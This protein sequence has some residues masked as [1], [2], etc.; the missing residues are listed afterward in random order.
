MSGRKRVSVLFA[1]VDRTICQEKFLVICQEAEAFLSR[2]LK[3]NFG[4][5]G[6]LPWHT[7]SW[8][9]QKLPYPLSPLAT[10]PTLW[11]GKGKK[12]GGP[13]LPCLGHGLEEGK[14]R[15]KRPIE[16]K[17]RK[18]DN[19]RPGTKK[20]TL[21]FAF[22]KPA[23]ISGHIKRAMHTFTRKEHTAGKRVSSSSSSL[24]VPTSHP[25]AISRVSPPPLAQDPPL[26]IH[27][28]FSPLSARDIW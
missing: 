13:F 3:C 11:D 23:S 26:P 25:H 4:L 10:A 6:A 8:T 20:K 14:A 17:N 9:Q 1:T 21:F 7:F 27:L 22:S 19:G 12:K 24:C 2:G 18:W 5:G 15:G 16:W 28:P